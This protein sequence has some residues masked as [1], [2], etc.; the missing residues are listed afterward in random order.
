MQ[1]YELIKM[2][3]T[4]DILNEYDTI[5]E[6]ARYKIIFITS[7]RMEGKNVR[8]LDSSFLVFYIF[9]FN[10]SIMGIYYF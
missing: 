5:S 1:Y 2:M 10:F 7:V 8:L 3:L 4:K 9:L 6:G